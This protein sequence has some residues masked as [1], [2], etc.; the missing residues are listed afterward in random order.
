MSHIHM[1]YVVIK[2]HFYTYVFLMRTVVLVKNK[3]FEKFQP[4]NATKFRLHGVKSKATFDTLKWGLFMEG[5]EHRKFTL[6]HAI[7]AHREGV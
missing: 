2:L 1:S 3:Y 4:K 5:K 6:W 7:K